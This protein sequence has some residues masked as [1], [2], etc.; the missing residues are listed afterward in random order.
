MATTEP[1]NYTKF[2]INQCVTVDDPMLT[3]NAFT[4]LHL[5]LQHHL[6]AIWTQN[7]LTPARSGQVLYKSMRI[8]QSFCKNAELHRSGSVTNASDPKHYQSSLAAS[9]I[10]RNVSGMVPHASRAPMRDCFV[11]LNVFLQ[12]FCKNIMELRGSGS[13]THLEGPKAI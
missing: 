4:T 3:Q 10:D 8:I 12:S 11:K 5:P 6:S 7:I 1:L 9:Q 2:C 13:G